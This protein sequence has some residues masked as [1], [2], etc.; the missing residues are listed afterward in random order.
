MF[1]KG[2]KGKTLEGEGQSK[3]KGPHWISCSEAYIP[4]GLHDPELWLPSILI[5][6][7]ED[8]DLLMRHFRWA[9]GVYLCSTSALET[10]H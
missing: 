8:L 3:G 2:C 7:E 4:G 1:Q 6:W 10:K 5:L 9:G